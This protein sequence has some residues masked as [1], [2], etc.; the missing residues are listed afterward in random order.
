MMLPQRVL[1]C[2]KHL[3]LNAIDICKTDNISQKL[4]RFNLIINDVPYQFQIQHLI[5]TEFQIQHFIFTEELHSLWSTSI[6]F[7]CWTYTTTISHKLTCQLVNHCA[8]CTHTSKH[9]LYV[10]YIILTV[11]KGLEYINI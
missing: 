4:K 11:K 7:I 3:Q 6:K 2:S 1:H 5:F 9:K 8:I 10:Y